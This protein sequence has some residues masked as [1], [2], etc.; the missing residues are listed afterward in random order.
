MSIP[1][2]HSDVLPIP[3]WPCRTTVRGSRS[4]RSRSWT[5]ASSS[6]LPPD[7]LLGHGQRY[8]ALPPASSSSASMTSCRER[9][10]SRH[11][12]WPISS[13]RGPV[14]G[15]LVHII[16][17]D[18][19]KALRSLRRPVMQGQS[20]ILRPPPSSLPPPYSPFPL[21]RLSSSPPPPLSSPPSPPSPPPPTPP[22]SYTTHPPLT[23]PRSQVMRTKELFCRTLERM[24]GLEPSTF[25]MASRRSSQLSYIRVDGEY[26]RRSAYPAA[27]RASFTSRSA[28]SLCSRRTAV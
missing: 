21:F 14:G 23:H 3:A 28:S 1:A 8:G 17:N 9:A 13:R 27:S 7:Q 25:C 22:P 18:A 19:H 24:K 5:I 12:S 10:P 2:S 4:R 6:V 20:S 16:R 26:S 11:G 15:R